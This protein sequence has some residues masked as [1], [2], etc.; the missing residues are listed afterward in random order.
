MRVAAT[1]PGFASTI[2]DYEAVRATVVNNAAPPAG[3]LP[4]V[5]SAFVDD[6]AGVASIV[7]LN[8]GSVDVAFKLTDATLGAANVTVAARSIASYRWLLA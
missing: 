8:A 3:G 7:V 1:G 5:A 2:A 4:L 6:A